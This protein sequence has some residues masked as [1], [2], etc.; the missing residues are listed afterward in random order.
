[1]DDTSPVTLTSYITFMFT[2]GMNGMNHIQILKNC[3]YFPVVLFNLFWSNIWLGWSWCC[4]VLMYLNKLKAYLV[5]EWLSCPL[6]C[7][8]C[9]KHIWQL[10]CT[11]EAKKRY[12][13]IS[14]V[15]RVSH[16]NISV[17][18]WALPTYTVSVTDDR[19]IWYWL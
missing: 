9:Y 15:A 16:P 13:F 18:T 19:N 6:P 2:Q 3:C 17:A 11:V 12:V 5:L 10:D 8:N 14:R 7:E 1:M 4:L